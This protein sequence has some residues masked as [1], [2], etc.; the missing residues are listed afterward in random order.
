[1]AKGPRTTE[2]SIISASLPT[3]IGPDLVFKIAPSITAPSSK[4]INF[5]S[6]ITRFVFD[7]SCDLL[8]AEINLKSASKTSL[9]FSY[10]CQR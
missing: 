1:M 4:K 3:Y 2:P 9:F 10:K 7:N 8:P 5:S 6:P